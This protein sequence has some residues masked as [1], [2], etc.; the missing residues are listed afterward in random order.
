M[1]MYVCTTCPS[2]QHCT[3]WDRLLLYCVLCTNF[4]HAYPDIF[5]IFGA[6]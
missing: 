3:A 5:L 2:H 6:P 4:L 1:L